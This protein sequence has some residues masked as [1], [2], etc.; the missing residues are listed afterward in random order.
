A[1]MASWSETAR[2]AARGL[3]A[4]VLGLVAAAAGAVDTSTPEAT[5]RSLHEGLVA[6]A[7]EHRGADLETRYRALEPLITATHDLPYIAEFA[8]RRQWRD[9]SEDERQRF[10]AAFTRLSVMTYASRFGGVGETSFTI[11][12]SSET[13]SGRAEIRAAIARAD[14]SAVPLE[15]LLE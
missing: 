3:G 1:R 15:Y 5:V 4:L 11:E 2:F 10:V 7:A 8:I 13:G 12:G 6:V 14:G 9:L